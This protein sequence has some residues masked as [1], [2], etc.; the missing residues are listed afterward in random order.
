MTQTIFVTGSAG[1]IGFHTCQFLL[2]KGYTVIGV[3]NLNDYYDVRLKQKRLEQLQAHDSYV[4]Y[5]EDFCDFKVLKDIVLKHSP[6]KIIHLGAQAGVRYSL[7]N[8]WE[9]ER[10][11]SLGTISVLEVARQTGIEKVVLA[12]SS[13]VYGGNT[14]VPFSERD[15][16]ERPVSVY[17]AT[18]RHT[19]LQ[20]HVYHHL[21]GLSVICLRFFTVYGTYLRP[22]LALFKFVK[23]IVLD[24]EIQL[25]NDG[26][27][28]RDFTYVGDI[29]EGII[30]ALDSSQSYGIYNLG[31]DNPVSLKDLVLCIEETLGKKALIQYTKMQQGDVKETMADITRAKKDLAFCPKTPL[32]EIVKEFCVWFESDKEFLCSLEDAKQ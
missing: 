12:S 31:G 3:D 32:P 17:A 1:F 20:A 5:T 7:E 6:S 27:M 2:K 26:D 24:E 10:V 14:K 9:Y 19:E 28:K 13:S 4:H 18:K 11:N 29:V 8:P 21:Y 15:S 30:A 16:V 23:K 25:Y 22:D